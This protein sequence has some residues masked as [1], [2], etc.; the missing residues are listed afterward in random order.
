MKLNVENITY[1]DRLSKFPT[2]FNTRR[3]FV[4]YL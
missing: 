4:K 2:I 1:S 3:Y